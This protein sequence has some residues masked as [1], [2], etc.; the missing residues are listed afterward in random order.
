VLHYVVTD[1]RQ[2]PCRCRVRTIFAYAENENAEGRDRERP[3][4]SRRG[5]KKTVSPTD[6]T[7]TIMMYQLFMV[8]LFVC[9]FVW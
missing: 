7:I 6:G 8:C 2:P 5:K 4:K 9:L 3:I 1:K